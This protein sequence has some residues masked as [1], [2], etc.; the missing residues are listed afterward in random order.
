M[1]L[2]LFALMAASVAALGEKNE[3]EKCVASSLCEACRPEELRLDFCSSTRRRI[4]ITCDGGTTRYES[5]D[6][7]AQD[8]L[9]DVMRFEA[10]MLFFGGISL[11]LVRRRKLRHQSLFDRRRLDDMNGTL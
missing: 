10:T 2:L 7:T 4:E 8:Q 1:A 6:E 11:Y 9:V 3:G 5:C